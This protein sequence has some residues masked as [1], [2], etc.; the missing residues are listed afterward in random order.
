MIMIYLVCTVCGYSIDI[1]SDDEANS[2]IRIKRIKYLSTRGQVCPNCLNTINRCEKIEAP[3]DQIPV[4]RAEIE[5]KDRSGF[6]EFCRSNG[7][8]VGTEYAF[9]EYRK[10]MA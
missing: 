8:A 5:E 6:V 1:V 4:M 2:P 7:Y 10:V 9:N 3:E